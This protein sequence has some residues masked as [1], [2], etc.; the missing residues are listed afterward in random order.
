MLKTVDSQKKLAFV[1]PRCGQDI[2]GGVETLFGKLAERLALTGY[3]VEILSTCAKD[4]RSWENFYPEGISHEFG[5]T[6]R[7]FKVDQR[8][9]ESWIPKQIRVQDGFLLSIEDQLE[10]MAESVNSRGLYQYLL[11]HGQ[12][13]DAIFFGPYQ[14]GTTFWGSMIHPER[15][16]LFP[17]L[18]AEV[19][20][21]IDVIR[22]MIKNCA[23]L[24]YNA[25]AEKELAEHYYGELKGGVVGMGFEFDKIP[26]SSQ[27][28]FL[29]Q[30][31]YVLYLGRKETGKNVH[32]LIDYFVGAK[33]KE[34]LPKE[35]KLVIAGAGDFSDLFRDSAL[36][37]D[38]V[39]DIKHV[40]EIEKSA[41][42]KNCLCLCQPSLNESFSIVIM[43]AWIQGAA[44]LVHGHCAVTKEHV[45]NS[46]G[47]LYFDS[48][49]E[50]AE[51][52]KLLL[53]EPETKS[54][55]AIAGKEYVQAVYNW[56]AVLERFEGVLEGLLK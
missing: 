4:N 5:V 13:Y 7:R 18:H 27:P 33:N 51:C 43:E 54:L 45:V 41:L 46:G 12:E 52:C 53:S 21:E 3:N 50:F 37:R 25:N 30:F 6:I 39:I 34:L 38:D 11:D 44:V 42:I 16:F 2:A 56:D 9:L 17:C 24:I 19:Y 48:E 10:W 40:T 26:N 1:A 35:L 28:Y 14:F 8:D 36:E 15:S 22:A 20:A 47:G 23:G 55:L 29:E 31:P 32:N 49:L